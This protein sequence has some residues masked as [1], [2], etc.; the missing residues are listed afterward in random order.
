M[1][2]KRSRES[3]ARRFARL[4]CRFGIHV[5]EYSGLGTRRYCP[6]DGKRQ[7]LF[8]DPLNRGV[9]VWR[10][11]EFFTDYGYK[12]CNHHGKKSCP[13]ASGVTIQDVNLVCGENCH[14]LSIDK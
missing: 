6:V 2:N 14:Y 1:K 11:V 9:R 7:E 4:C 10:D 3:I 13:L 12:K 8:D 5:F